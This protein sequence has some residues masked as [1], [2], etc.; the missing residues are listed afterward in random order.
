M[1]DPVNR[2]GG[3]DIIVDDAGHSPLQNFMFFYNLVTTVRP[4]GYYVCEDLAAGAFRTLEAHDRD[5]PSLPEAIRRATTPIDMF[6]DVTGILAG[7][8]SDSVC[9][10]CEASLAAVHWMHETVIFERGGS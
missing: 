3:F 6:T 4:G 9:D 8:S 2:G 1:L 7:G 5:R 10:G